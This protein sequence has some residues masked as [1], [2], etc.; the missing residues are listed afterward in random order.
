MPADAKTPRTAGIV[1][2][3][4][5]A[6]IAA[7][8][9]GRVFLVPI[10]LAI[11]FTALLRPVVRRFER[12]GLSAPIG[13]SVVLVVFVGFLVTATMA[14]ADPVRGWIA[15][16]P[17][18]FAAA[19]QRLQ[20]LR[21]PLQSITAAAQKV[22]QAA[23]APAAD[24]GTG[25]KTPGA[26]APAA[27]PSGGGSNP[28]T[29]AARVFGTT[30]SLLA[31]VVEVVLL[32]FLLLASGDAFMAKLVKVLPVRRDK[33]EAVVIANEA[34]T[35]VS[36]Y[37][38]ATALINL[39]QGVLVALS[40]WLLHLPNPLIWGLL[41]FVLEFIPFLGG[42][43]MMILLTLAGL[44]TFDGVGRALLPPAVYLTISTLQ[45]NLVSP[46]AYGRRLRLN[47]VAI[48]VGVLFWYY[49]WGVP[50]AFLAV[51]IIA[52]LKI[53]GEHVEPLGP[54]AEFLGE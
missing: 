12:A 17:D 23:T 35:V 26:A 28:A 10:A 11:L 31:G 50:G 46:V 13:A 8:Y 30:T 25:R 34:E 19:Q 24:S 29:L 1:I 33:R 14:L 44:A 40:M 41:T 5:L 9:V 3:A 38:V 45:N 53:I 21:R 18:T 51:P 7:L 20:Q 49:L 52:T 27:A 32:T 4:T 39:G 37:M 48:L 43:G 47:P 16:A 6:V 54:L 42:A 36:H 15:Q 2:L 22:E